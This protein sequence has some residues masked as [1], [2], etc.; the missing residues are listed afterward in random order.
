MPA[1]GGRSRADRRWEKGDRPREGPGTPGARAARCKVIPH[2]PIPALRGRQPR[3]PPPA[4]PPQTPASGVD[5]EGRRAPSPHSPPETLP[6]LPSQQESRQ[7]Q[8]GRRGGLLPD[9]HT[10]AT[11][12]LPQ[13]CPRRGVRGSGP[14]PGRPRPAQP[15]C[16]EKGVHVRV[17]CSSFLRRPLR[18]VHD[19]GRASASSRGPAKPGAEGCPEPGGR[20]ARGAAAAAADPLGSGLRGLEAGRRGWGRERRA[21]LKRRRA[22]GWGRLPPAPPWSPSPGALAACC[23]P[24]P[25]PGRGPGCLGARSCSAAAA[26]SPPR[27]SACL[28]C[29]ALLGSPLYFS[30]SLPP[31]L[32]LYLLP[33]ALA[34]PLSGSPSGSRRRRR[35]PAP[36]P[37]PAPQS[38]PTM[39]GQRRAPLRLRPGPGLAADPRRRGR[40]LAPRPGA[41]LSG[42]REPPRAI[43]PAALGRLPEPPQ[44]SPA[45]GAA[46]GAGPPGA[47]GLALGSAPRPASRCARGNPKLLVRLLCRPL[48]GLD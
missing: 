4:S 45:R 12:L 9:M 44:E 21:S 32:S 15:T 13:T 40:L 42:G 19:W 18:G 27:P 28:Y 38:R 31:S 24:G 25:G 39:T 30:S 47:R 17:G 6:A 8:P 34:R 10:A 11:A 26:G 35:L 43:V 22:A 23:L 20:R 36:P 29:S 48:P 3:A 46:G 33:P 2:R 14:A 5:T 1:Q 41:G 37:A 7:L 16:P